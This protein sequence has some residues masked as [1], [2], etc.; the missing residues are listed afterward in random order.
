MLLTV[1]ETVESIVFTPESV[2]GSV[3]KNSHFKI[4]IKPVCV[5]DTLNTPV[6]TNSGVVSMRDESDVVMD[7]FF[8]STST[9]R[10][11]R[12]LKIVPTLHWKDVKFKLPGTLL[13][14]RE[15]SWSLNRYMVGN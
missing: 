11:P 13:T 14:V 5:S 2:N 6:I 12:L 8:I 9:K 15:K 7:T 4:I 1:V 3:C 10:Y